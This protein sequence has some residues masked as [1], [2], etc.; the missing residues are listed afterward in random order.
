MP[1]T[2]DPPQNLLTVNQ[3]AARLQLSKW[4][5]Y[6]R[7]ADGQIPALKLGSDVRS[8]L[9]VPEDELASWLYGDPEEP[10]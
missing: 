7:V 5:V 8:P 4:S 10:A 2:H 6:R 3:V 1:N 9:R